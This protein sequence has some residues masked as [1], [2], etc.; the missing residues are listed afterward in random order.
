MAAKAKAKAKGAK[1]K[2]AKPSKSPGAGAPAGSRHRRTRPDSAPT[3]RS[4]RP[5]RKEVPPLFSTYDQPKPPG[6]YFDE[7]AADHAVKWIEGELRHFKGRWAGMRFLLMKWQ[8]RL[9]RHVFGWRRKDGSRLIRKVYVEAPRKSGKTSL[10]SAIGGYMGYGLDEAAPEVYFAA[11][12][13]EQ[14]RISYDGTRNMIEA[15]PSL[16]ERSLVYNSTK[17]ILISDNPGGILKALSNESAKQFGHNLWALIFDELMTQ[18]TRM[19]WDA[20]TTAGGS[21]I[22]PLVFA[23]STAGWDTESVCFEQHELTRAIH[24]GLVED[25]AFLGVI[26]GADV[27]ADWT[28]PAVWKAANPSLGETVRLDYYEDKCREAMNSPTA[29]NAFRTLLLSQWVGQAERFID[30]AVWD[31]NAERPLELEEVEGRP[32]AFGG[33]DLSSTTDLSALTILCERD[34]KIDWHLWAYMPAGKIRQRERRDRVPYSSWAE[35]GLLTLIPGDTIDQDYIRADILRAAEIF[36]LVD[37]GYDPWNASQLVVECENEG[38]EMV[39]V[40]Q[41]F[42]TM[43]PPTKRFATLTIEGKFRAGENPLL[44]WSIGN[45]A[46]ATDAAGNLKP[47]KARTSHRIDPPVSGIIALDGLMRR[48]SVKKKRSI[49]SRRGPVVARSR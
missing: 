17:E 13:K 35:Q 40:R 31:E 47:D 24:E 14:A 28:D 18:R 23:I 48:G 30:V 10:A 12:D 29:Q 39:K 6:A 7:A 32:P 15:S 2:S 44:R 5:R 36:E 22:D 49:Y 33:L 37:V 25:P 1:P 21:R 42:A 8:I 9:V 43:S 41:G 16:F 45:L 26:Y 20:L 27:E 3:K 34:G 4:I 19:L 38:I 46:V 11:F